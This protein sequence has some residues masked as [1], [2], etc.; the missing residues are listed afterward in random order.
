MKE[1]Y[2]IPIDG[3]DYAV[4]LE[5]EEILITKSTNINNEIKSV[6]K[7]K[8]KDSGCKISTDSKIQIG[9]SR[10][11]TKNMP[12]AACFVSK[13]LKD[14]LFVMK[15]NNIDNWVCYVNSEGLIV[16]GREGIFGREQLIDIIDELGILGTLKIA[17]SEA[18]K[19][20][21]FSEDSLDYDFNIISIQ[22][23]LGLNK[24]TSDDIVTLLVKEGSL[25][26]K[27]LYGAVICGIAGAGYYL[28]FTEDQLFVDIVN[29]ELSLPLNAKEQAFD[30]VYKENQ[31]KIEESIYQNSGKLMLREKVESNIY[32]KKEIYEHIKELYETYPLYFYEWE[33]DSIQF[34]KSDDNKDIKFSVIYRRIENS[35]GFYS[36]IKDKAI[37]L[38]K[39]KFNLYNINA[40]PGDLDNNVIIIDHYFKKPAELKADQPELEI[41]NKLEADKKKAEK[42]I[43]N[44]KSRITETEYRVGTE[45]GFFARKFG[46]DVQDA[47]D[48]IEGDVASGIKIYDG[49]IKSYKN[50]GQKEIVIPDS[51]YNGNK[52][53]F[54]NMIQR[55]SFYVWRDEKQ[56]QYL[57]PP[58]SDREKLENFKAFA[59]SWDF[60]MNSSSYS[61]QGVGSIER[62]VDLLDKTD[63]SIYTV[64]YKIE[65]ETWYIKGE[66]YEKN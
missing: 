37:E 22:E 53:D 21:I 6:A 23:I 2:S 39:S 59:K 46:S 49:L 62:A 41:M 64:N 33:F 12:V 28:F 5:W 24:K 60:T 63:I 29:Q 20:E 38:A 35:I 66:L 48:E 58:P 61:T 7:R 31:A 40:Y 15:V 42:Q 56:P 32:T 26:S 17:C 14:T 25:I 36:E 51:Y 11:N 57:P 3:I 43:E 13:A 54:V 1:I 19:E 55:N 8:N 44:I 9:L 16:D 50:S 52:N 4:G 27:L 47:A 18:D 34:V 10:P 30:K 65:T 45:L